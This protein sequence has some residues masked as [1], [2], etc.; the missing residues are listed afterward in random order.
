MPSLL[1]PRRLLTPVHQVASLARFAAAREEREQEDAAAQT[2][3][4]AP[5][6]VPR[7]LSIRWLGVAGYELTYEG[8]TLLIDPY[9]SRV[10]LPP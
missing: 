10:P 2:A 5:L 9:V 4:A 8:Q 7:G 3:L 6:G 1:D